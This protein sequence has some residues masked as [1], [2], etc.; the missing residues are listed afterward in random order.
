MDPRQPP[1]QPWSSQADGSPPPPPPPPGGVADEN[2][3]LDQRNP[4]IVNDP[5]CF[6]PPPHGQPAGH[7]MGGW[8]QLQPHGH[9]SNWAPQQGP[10]GVAPPES[11]QRAS[12]PAYQQ[13]SYLPYP[14]A[15]G[16]PG[17][18]SLPP[19]VSTPF[20]AQQ[21]AFGPPPPLSGHEAAPPGVDHAA[22]L[23]QQHCGSTMPYPAFMPMAAGLMPMSAGH[24]GLLGMT[25]GGGGGGGGGAMDPYA[26]MQGY[27]QRNGYGPIEGASYAG[28]R[29]GY[30]TTHSA[31]RRGRMRCGLPMPIWNELDARRVLYVDPDRLENSPA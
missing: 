26:H 21:Q 20:I 11:Y 5:S 16:M 8:Q 9:I 2:G 18:H 3:A 19:G 6:G 23:Y 29:G 1:R 27:P 25:Q 24:T 28:R 7:V 17:L 12:G 22:E 10:S 31:Y 15:F 30:E 4:R 13:P 14:P